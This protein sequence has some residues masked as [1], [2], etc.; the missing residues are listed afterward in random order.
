[1]AILSS[2]DYAEIR[3]AISTHLTDTDL[4]DAVIA[5]DAFIGAAEQE[6]LD[7]Y[8]D[9]GSAAGEAAERVRRAAIYLTAARL[10][11]AT[12]VITSLSAQGR[13]LNYSVQPYDPDARQQELRGYAD[14]EL[15]AIVRPTER[16]PRRFSM[17]STAGAGQDSRLVG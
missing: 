10:A 8:P 5:Q 14:A 17:F 3:A 16:A 9:A 13:D 12:V 4:P 6:V 1:M 2:A 7:R 11:P 15:L